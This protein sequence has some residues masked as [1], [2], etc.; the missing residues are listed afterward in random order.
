M[1][2]H[3]QDI[4]VRKV[5]HDQ[6]QTKIKKNSKLYTSDGQK[7]IQQ[8]SIKNLRRHLLFKLKAES[9]SEKEIGSLY[10]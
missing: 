7:S 8:K 9:H 6:L 3:H 4:Q 1:K 10:T 5:N 2:K